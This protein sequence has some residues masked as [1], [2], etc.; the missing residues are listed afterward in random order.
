MKRIVAILCALMML[1]GTLPT[2]AFADDPE[3]PVIESVDLAPETE[4]LQGDQVEGSPQLTQ[5]EAQKENSETNIS[6][7]AIA[8]ESIRSVVEEEGSAYF[9]CNYPESVMI[10]AETTDEEPLCEIT[11]EMNIFYADQ[12]LRGT[13]RNVRHDHSDDAAILLEACE[14]A[15][16]LLEGGE[17]VPMAV[18]PTA[19]IAAYRRDPNPDCD[20]I[21]DY[22]SKLI[23]TLKKSTH[24]VKDSAEFRELRL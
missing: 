5:E 21:R 11:D 7:E 18:P 23:D 4:E 1:I 22:L 2:S 3:V 17:L 12:A 20:E 19:R 13:R 15:A 8:L 16:N 6:P 24:F 9:V 14:F 10:Y